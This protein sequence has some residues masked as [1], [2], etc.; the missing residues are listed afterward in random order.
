[1][2]SAKRQYTIDPGNPPGRPLTD[3]GKLAAKLG[4]TRQAAWYRLR[5][6]KKAKIVKPRRKPTRR[7]K[8]LDALDAL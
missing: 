7:T 6:S 3:V 4:I 2:K 5:R 8:L 1:M